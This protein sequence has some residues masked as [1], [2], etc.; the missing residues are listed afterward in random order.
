MALSCAVNTTAINE[1]GLF[2]VP[3][4]MTIIENLKKEY[5]TR[6][7]HTCLFHSARNGSLSHALVRHQGGTGTLDGITDVASVAGLLKL[8]LRELPEPLLVFRFYSTFVKIASAYH[9]SHLQ[10]SW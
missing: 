10:R 4:Q 7:L 1:E 3:G 9:R 6:T 5:D 8:Y 2:R